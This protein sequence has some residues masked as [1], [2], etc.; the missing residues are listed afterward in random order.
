MDRLFDVSERIGNVLAIAAKVIVG[1]MVC[2]VAADVTARNLSRSLVWSVSLVEYLMV[3][4]TFLAMPALVRTKGHVCADF[5]RMSL[6]PRVQAV[7]ERFVY[8]LCL[9][10]CIY[11]AIVASRV[12][13][14][15]L[16]SGSYDVRTFDMPRWLIFLPMVLGLWLSALEFLR[17]LLGRDSIYAIAAADR[18]SL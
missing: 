17:Y 18:E 7:L 5:I 13:L 6:P 11:L 3:Y 15:S 1:L 4:M 9:S 10:L 8:L 16:A 2:L 14:E 12:C